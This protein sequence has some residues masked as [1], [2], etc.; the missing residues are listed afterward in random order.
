MVTEAALEQTEHGRV[1]ADDGWFVL[2]ARDARW[3]V[4]EMGA[5]CPFEGE[6]RFAQLGINLNVLPPGAPMA[7]YHRE[8]EQEDFLVLAGECVLIVEDEE[9]PLRQWDFFHCPPGTAHVIVGAG[10]TP[11]LVLAVGARSGAGGLVY[12]AS[13]VAR[14][15][16]AGVDRE[17]SDPREAYARFSAPETSAYQDGW[18]PGG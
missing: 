13:D 4:N 5:Y 3:Q 11:C 10:A 16:G 15:H 9:R 18:L 1:P 17:T 6:A 14:H 7:M 8:D 12:P 2:N